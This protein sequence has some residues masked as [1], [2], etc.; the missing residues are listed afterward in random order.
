[1]KKWIQSTQTSLTL[2]CIFLLIALLSVNM[3]YFDRQ[4]SRNDNTIQEQNEQIGLLSQLAMTS[5]NLSYY[6]RTYA[7]I[8][9]IEY[10]KSYWKLRQSPNGRQDLLKAMAAHEHSR[11]E[12]E[13]SALLKEN[14]EKLQEYELLFLQYALKRYQV[15]SS[16]YGETQPLKTY[17]ID[18]ENYE[19]T[20]SELK[21][22]DITDLDVTESE[23][24]SWQESFYEREA[25][26]K[27]YHFLADEITKELWELSMLAENRVDELDRQNERIKRQIFV[28]QAVSLLLATVCV[29][30]L[31]RQ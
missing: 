15:N 2:I 21:E 3:G 10:F 7:A 14:C 6:M 25:F 9:D 12:R 22:L 8:G 30:L 5:S 29:I 4:L 31:M 20:N 13:K 24:D 23:A 28:L 11:A 1:M 16:T 26:V 19:F 18:T 27:T 17:I